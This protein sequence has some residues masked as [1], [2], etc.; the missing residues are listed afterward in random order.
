MS[1]V[2]K[3]PY[4]FS[5]EIA[6]LT[7]RGG[8]EWKERFG[9]HR[10]DEN[11]PPSLC[12][13]FIIENYLDYQGENAIG[14]IDPN[15]LLYV[16]KV[17]S[18]FCEIQFNLLSIICSTRIMVHL[19]W[20]SSTERPISIPWN[21]IVSGNTSIHVSVSVKTPYMCIISR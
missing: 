6:T 17:N 10:I 18:I 5:R 12:P 8:D 19:H 1:V 2:I 14:K 7:Y 21:S 13:Y 15:T 11:E 3:Q 16:S 20:P 4:F 9:R